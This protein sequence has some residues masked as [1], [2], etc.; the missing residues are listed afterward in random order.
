MTSAALNI[1]AD[2]LKWNSSLYYKYTVFSPKAEKD[3]DCYEYLHDYYERT[4]RCLRIPSKFFQPLVN[5]GGSL[6][7]YIY[8]RM[9]L[10]RVIY[11]TAFMLST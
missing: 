4:N 8:S 3:E 9:H 6:L 11:V 10:L 5:H 7:L 1:D 2:I